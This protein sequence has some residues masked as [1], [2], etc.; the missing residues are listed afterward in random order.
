M[1]VTGLYRKLLRLYPA[2]FR[3]EYEGAMDR[4]F[5]DEQRDARGGKKTLAYGCT[6]S[7][8]LRHPRRGN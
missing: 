2:S 3:Q 6:L 4:Q 1:D 7:Q 8:I 5:R